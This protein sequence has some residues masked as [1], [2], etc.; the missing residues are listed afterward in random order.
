MTN[1]FFDISPKNGYQKF[2]PDFDLLESHFPDLSSSFETM[3]NFKIS[4]KEHYSIIKYLII[5]NGIFIK[6]EF[7]EKIQTLLKIKAT[8]IPANIFFLPIYI[9]AKYDRFERHFNL[10]TVINKRLEEKNVLKNISERLL[11]KGREKVNVSFHDNTTGKEIKIAK[12]ITN[13]P[14]LKKFLSVAIEEYHNS[15]ILIR[16]GISEDAINR[17]KI[18]VTTL[19]KELAISVHSYL[20]KHTSIKAKKGSLTSSTQLDLIG[21]YFNI[22]ELTDKDEDYITTRENIL[23]YITRK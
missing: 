7:C 5:K 8:E 17:K 13:D 19:K 16:S 12:S 9:Y 21:L 2:E 14:K 22:C 20:Q 3:F 1:T 23:R 11:N 18:A 4:G 15:D 6:P 10:K